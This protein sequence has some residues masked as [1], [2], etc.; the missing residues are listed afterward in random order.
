MATQNLVSAS[1]TPEAKGAILDS[2]ADVRSKL[3][4][5]LTLRSDEKAG[6]FKA[7]KEYGPFLAEC[8]K[9]AKAHPDILPGVFNTAEFDRDYQLAQDVGAIAD[10]LE[11]LAEGVSHTLTAGRSDALVAALDVYAAVK[12]NRDKVPGLGGVADNLGTY[13]KRSPKAAAK[14]AH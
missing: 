8:H 13:F 10:T 1:I 5:L 7:G 6:I 11:Q 3:G 12:L 14:A 2:L 4:F 9:V